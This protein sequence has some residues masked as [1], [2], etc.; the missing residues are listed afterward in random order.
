MSL[1]Y[2]RHLFIY[3]SIYLFPLPFRAAPWHM[4]TPRLGVE[5]ELQPLGYATATATPD[6]SHICG[7]HHSSRQCQILNL[8][9]KARDWTCVLTDTS[10]ICYHWATTG[11]P[12]DIYL[13]SFV[14]IVHFKMI[15]IEVVEV[16]QGEYFPSALLNS[17]LGTL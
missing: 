17:L 4:E 9:S 2:K 14:W 1:A 5:S 8:L 7:L 15:S 6:P 16:W 13:Y 11:T 12:E 3:L 10:Q